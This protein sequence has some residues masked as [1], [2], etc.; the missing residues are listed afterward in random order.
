[1]K[2]W[3]VLLAGCCVLPL[4]VGCGGTAPAP[5]PVLLL[6]GKVLNAGAPLVADKAKLGDYARVEV[7]FI[8]LAGQGQEFSAIPDQDG[9][10]TLETADG[11]NLP[12]GKYKVA[13]RQWEPYPQTDKLGGKFDE[14][15]SPIVVEITDPPKD[16]EIDI[17]K[18]SG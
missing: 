5:E 18:P 4:S 15:R 10:F 13:V 8:P 1:M 17:A 3:L 7:K 11:K 14:Q 2:I 9:T 12:P 6:R 16:V